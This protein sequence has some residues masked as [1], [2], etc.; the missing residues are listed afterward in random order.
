MKQRLFLPIWVLFLFSAIIPL[1]SQN[2]DLS[3]PDTTANNGAT[4]SLGI[5]ADGFDRIVSMQFTI[6]WD[7]TVIEYLDYTDAA[8]NNVAIGD[9]DS[10]IGTLRFSWFDINGMGVDLPDESEL[11][12]L[13]FRVIGSTGTSTDVFI[14][15]IP[16][17]I[18]IFQATATPGVFVPV[19]LT[20][21]VGTVTVVS[22]IEVMAESFR[23][24]CKG[25][26]GGS[27]SL[28]I[29]EDPDTL[30]VQWVG[31]DGYMA[32]SL[33]IDSLFAGDYNLVIL[34]QQG[35]ILIDT[36][37][38]VGEPELELIITQVLIEDAGCTQDSGFVAYSATGG[39]SPYVFDIGTG[40]VQEG[41]FSNLS[42]GDYAITVADGFGCRISD[43]FL[44][45]SIPVPEVELGPPIRFCEGESGTL[46]IEG[47]FTE[48]LWSTGEI[49]SEITVATQDTFDVAVTNEFGCSAVDT[50]F[51]FVDSAIVLEIM[52]PVEGICPGDSIEIVASGAEVYEWSEP[53]SGTIS[54]RFI[55]NPMVFPDSVNTVYEVMGMNN[56]GEDIASVELQVFEITATAGEDTCIAIGDLAKLNASGGVEYSWISFD[57]PIS[58]FNI[59]DPETSP[60]ETASYSLSILDENGCTTIDSVTVVVANDIA[61]IPPINFISPNDDGKNDV[62][63]FSGLE[64]FGENSLRVFNRWGDQVYSKVNY[65]QDEERFDG[66][67]NGRKLPAGNYFYVLSFRGERDIKQTLLI[68][69][70]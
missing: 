34:D 24:P 64:K 33:N 11:V 18:Q 65:Q 23:S 67:K 37:I 59:P 6:N 55:P 3:L 30:N 66:T 44:I 43:N 36:T 45:D 21:D 39:G 1:R 41:S 8:L 31:P 53:S 62:L 19:F 29:S 54:D 2:I 69:R 70:E 26:N 28:D 10:N 27:I 7:P 12:K 5:S 56:C 60:E 42:P 49:T 47:D 68:V 9:M 14:N 32:D 35:A 52:V 38:T 16:L 17:Q 63:E 25:G 46:S 61:S 50:T 13:N 15:G 48:I 4:V 51:V 40:F 20:Q 57:A 22:G 58:N